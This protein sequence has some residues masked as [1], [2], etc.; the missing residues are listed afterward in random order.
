[1][2][3]SPFFVASAWSATTFRWLDPL[4]ATGNRKPLEHSD[5]ASLGEVNLAS[6]SLDA[7]QRQRRRRC[8]PAMISSS[9][10]LSLA[11]VLIL[12][13]WKQVMVTGGLSLL[14]LLVS[15]VGPL[16]IADFVSRSPAARGYALAAAFMA[17]KLATNLLERQHNF[18][19][20]VMDLCVQ[21]SLKGFVFWKAMETGAAAAPSIT[22][23]SSDV[24]EVGVFCWHLHDF[25]TLPLQFIIGILVLY[26]DVGVAAL[27]SFVSLGVCIACSFPLGKKQASFQGRVM[28]TKGARLR[29]TSEALRSMR[30]LKLHGWE[31]SFLREVEKLRDGEYQE[32]QRCFFVRA[33]SK[34]VFRVTP[35]VMA[36]LTLV[37][38]VVITSS[39]HS[40]TSGKLLS[41]LAVF[42][43]LQNVQS[44]LPGFASS[45][46]DVWVSLDRLSEFYQREDVTFQPKQLMSGGRNAIEISRGVFSWD[47]NAAT[48]TLDAVTLDVVEGSFVV[49]S[50]GVGSGK[51]SLLSCILGQIPK[52]SGEVRVRGTTS[53]TCQSAW[54]QNATIKENIL[55][56]SAMDKPR[57][58]RVIAACQLKKDL[59]MLSH[60]DGTHIGD[61]G[62]NLSG[63][64]KQRL[65]LARAVYK[66]AD[67]YLLD[68]P[69]SALDV[70]TSNLILKE[71]ILGLLQNK[72]VLLVTHFQEAAKQAD[73]T[74]VLQEGTV[75]ILDHLVDKG[76]PQ[77]SLDNYAAT[78]QNQGETSIV[79][80]KQ[81]G[82]LA[83]ETQRGSVSGKIYW[84][85]ITSIYG[86]ALVPLILAFEAIRQGTDAAATWWIADMDPKLDS[87]QL[88]M[89]YFVLSL[90][91][92]LALLCR[93][94]LVS[95]VGLKTGQC[96]FLKL[97]RSVFLATMSFFDLTPVGRILTRASTDQSSIDLYVPERFSELALFA[98]DLLVILVVTCSVA[99]PIL[100]VFIFL[101]I[102]GYKLQSFYIKTIR[103]L[104]RLV[105]L[106]RAS[107]VH[108]LEETLTGLST[109]KA[110]KQE[111]PFLNKMLQL[112]DDNNCPQF[113]N[114]SAM[115]FLALRVGL[116]A[117]MAFVFLMLFLASIP[118]SASSAGVAVT[119]GLKLTT[120]LTWTLWSRIDTEKRIISVERVM[121]YAGLR[122]E[123][124]DQS[125][126]PQTW[127]ENGAIDFIGLKVRYT[128]EAPLVLRGI[129]CGFSGGSK[130]GV[131]GR[132][133]S[134]KSTLIQ[135]LFRIVE[136]SSGRILVDGLDI[137][138][139]NLH[140]LRSRLSIIPQD[141][142]VFEGSFRYNL[143]PVGQY[144]D[145]EIWEVLQMCE[146]VAT[147]TA[148]GEGLDSKVSGSGENWSMG[149]K[150]L[151]CLARIMLKRT[152][153]VVLDEATATIDGATERIIQEKIN[154]HFQSSTV[155][156]VAHRLSTIVQNTERVLVL[157]DGKHPKLYSL[158]T[159]SLTSFS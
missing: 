78:E 39:R 42:R 27:A 87:S 145:H 132:T 57:Y 85:Y 114:F 155:L 1:M 148:K 159:L 97:Y 120:T 139:V 35:T 146:L 118:T 136:P 140:S 92:S 54:I 103:E 142:V 135:A 117:D 143:D 91:S 105:E 17:A 82:K 151:L 93:V 30:T 94:L 61:R 123:A 51:S 137:T 141:P 67:I 106:Q 66:D 100:W 99:W 62:V 126:P 149:E 104:P 2:A 49:V 16:L 101:A 70:K 154:E 23:V 41:T 45:V 9:R 24:L 77:S 129:T 21:S 107:V 125:Q 88:V 15:F 5:L 113:Y 36:V 73:K 19:I 10:G 86:G 68:D 26:R 6:A 13:H 152:K 34:F 127:P 22:L 14:L 3:A 109:I 40:L 95:F 48:P 7:F 89:V 115:E 69:L 50:G 128:P 12:A 64:Q 124:R 55:F 83:E 74:I 144:S 8:G 18:R 156:T 119:Y 58:E 158:G 52:L 79:S 44:K 53:Y 75:K 102:V 116:V 111:L 110:F 98:M 81:E 20:Q 90:G 147:I 31:T 133:G 71:C 130:V 56:D 29:A 134:G 28:K 76:F 108:H 63:G 112:I 72:T 96:F 43:L 25:W 46:V 11:W 121:Q 84:V 47:R 32:L 153:I 150:Q 65:Q 157:Q 80:S 37:M 33:L 138:T 4:F 131:V 60:G 38:S 59:E 122:S